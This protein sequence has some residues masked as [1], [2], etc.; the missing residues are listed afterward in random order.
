MSSSGGSHRVPHSYSVPKGNGGKVVMEFVDKVYDQAPGFQVLISI[1]FCIAWNISKI[2]R[3][4]SLD[5]RIFLMRSR[6]TCSPLSSPWSRA[7]LHSLHPDT[8]PSRPKTD[9]S[10]SLRLRIFWFK[11][12]ASQIVYCSNPCVKFILLVICIQLNKRWSM[13]QEVKLI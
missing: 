8:S 4:V 6:S 11:T 12:S 10:H 1:I 3:R 9:L 2:V 5:F 7:S 13:R